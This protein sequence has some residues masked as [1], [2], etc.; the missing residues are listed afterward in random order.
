MEIWKYVILVA[1]VLLGGAGGVL[2]G[3]S[4]KVLLPIALSFTAA[5]ILGITV[6]SLLPSV[7]IGAS[8][9]I[10][11]WMLVGFLLQIAFEY[12][13]KGVEHGHI[14]T[15]SHDHQLVYVFQV[16]LGLS[17]H[18]FLE[19]L[20]ISGFSAVGH[21]HHGDD[22]F[23]AIIVHK[24]PAAFA[25][26]VLLVTQGIGRAKAIL[27]LLLF[28]MMSPLG[29]W[30]GSHWQTDVEVMRIFLAILIGAFFHISTLILFEN[31]EDAGKHHHFSLL[32]MLTILVGFFLAYLVS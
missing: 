5:Y 2:F 32:K 1:V 23:W 9:K 17:L 6:M 22:L 19:G 15:H 28:A 30:L 3:G 10:G 16:L 27:L 25:L 8:A 26:S 31:D 24:A 21:H 20:P 4:R 13:S 11:I 14:H 18:A 12:L 7:Y 29:A